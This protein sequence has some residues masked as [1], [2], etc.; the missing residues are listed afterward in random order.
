[1]EMSWKSW[2]ELYFLLD[3]PFALWYFN[4]HYRIR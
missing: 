3:L 1:M 2:A 4:R